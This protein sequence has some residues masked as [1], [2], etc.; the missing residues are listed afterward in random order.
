MN[1]RNRLPALSFC[2][3]LLTSTGMAQSRPTRLAILDFG[4]ERT[5]LHAAAAIRENLNTKGDVREFTLLDRDQIS[6]AAQG[7]G[8][9]GSLNLTI[10][11]ARDLGTTMDCDF[12]LIGDAQTLRRSPSA[13]PDYYE[14]YATLFLVSAR[15]GRLIHWEMPTAQSDAPAQAE[16]ALLAILSSPATR[17]RYFN[18]LRRAQEA[19]RAERITAVE[20]GAQIIEVMSDD[21]SNTKEEVRAPRPF[22]RVKPPYP[23]T[24][25]RAE[26]EAT[27]DVLADID[28]RGEV[29]RVEI[30]RWAGYGLDQSVT[31]TVKQMHFFPAMRDGVAVPMRVLLRYNFR[32]PPPEQNRSQ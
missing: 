15:T 6:A 30:T 8:F 14:S 10:Q 3:L 1:L 26:V 9:D 29:G 24:A 11:Q 19:E 18:A 25:A 28:A 31:E 20:T 32:K 4:K 22:R 12:F 21:N 17:Q 13:K 2:L 16:K 5:G 23:E 27:V 7:A